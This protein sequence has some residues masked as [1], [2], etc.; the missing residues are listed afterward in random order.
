MIEKKSSTTIDPERES[1]IAWGIRSFRK[2][3]RHTVLNFTMWIAV[4]R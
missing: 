3:K 4:G 1:P 2:I